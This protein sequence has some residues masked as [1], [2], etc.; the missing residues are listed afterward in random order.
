MATFESLCIFLLKLPLR[1]ELWTSCESITIWRTTWMQVQ[2]RKEAVARNCFN[3]VSR[4]LD[5]QPDLSHV[6]LV[7]HLWISEFAHGPI[8]FG[9]CSRAPADTGL[10][11]INEWMITKNRVKDTLCLDRWD[12]LQTLALMVWLHKVEA[13]SS[14]T[15]STHHQERRTATW[16]TA[17]ALITGGARRLWVHYLLCL[18]SSAV[19]SHSP[20]R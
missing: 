16:Q 1:Y 17:L 5:T 8:G 2:A 7:F 3:I 11:S 10:L 4:K 12:K 14:D 9:H 18:L 20:G 6:T 15:H 13:N 19:C